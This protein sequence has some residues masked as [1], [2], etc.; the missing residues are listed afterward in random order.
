MQLRAVIIEDEVNSREILRNYLKNYCS[1][2]TI[3]GEARHHQGRNSP[4][5]KG[6][7]KF[8]V[9]GCGNAIW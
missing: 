6:T 8:S 9:P 3:L 1:Q 2:V 7:A 4:D 5:C